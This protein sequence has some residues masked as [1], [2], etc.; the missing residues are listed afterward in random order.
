MKQTPHLLQS[1]VRKHAD[2]RTAIFQSTNHS[3]PYP[4]AKHSHPIWQFGNLTIWQFAPS[5]PT[6][7]SPLATHLLKAFSFV[8]VM[9]VVVVIGILAAVVVPRF[10][11]VTEESRA[12]AV[13][14]ALGSAR[15]SIAAFRAQSL[16]SGAATYPTFAQLT[17]TGT[18]LRDEMPANPY[19]K[20]RGIQQVSATQAAARAVIN[21]TAAG[22]NYYVDNSS[23]PP[24]VIFYANDDTTTT[25]PNGQG[26]FLAANQL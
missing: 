6:R 3:R 14:A 22:W 13:Q 11:G 17:T 5:H 16:L 24:V 26:G 7:H 10:A 20:T 4:T 8:E 18:V 12:S 15:G 23:S 19:T 9:L 21:P 1:R 2:K 25:I